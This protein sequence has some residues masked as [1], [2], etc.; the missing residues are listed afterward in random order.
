[1]KNILIHFFVKHTLFLETLRLHPPG[2][3]TNRQCIKD[4]KIPDQDVIIEKG[5]SVTIPILGIH[6][7]PEYYPN[8]EKFDPDR[9]TEENKN[10]R[11]NFTFLPF[12]E[13]PRN[14]IGKGFIHFEFVVYKVFLRNA[15]WIIT[16]KSGSSLID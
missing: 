3:M 11:H 16:V 15:F 6:H 4:Y 9:F 2:A 8:P 7:D 14:C 10:S 5:T 12:G 13:G 1:M